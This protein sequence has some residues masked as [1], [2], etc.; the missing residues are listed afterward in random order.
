MFEDPGIECI[1]KKKNQTNTFLKL[2]WICENGSKPDRRIEIRQ[3]S[4]YLCYY[5]G[6]HRKGTGV[7]RRL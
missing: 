2:F 5:F 3:K 1:N 4:E 7:P 6:A